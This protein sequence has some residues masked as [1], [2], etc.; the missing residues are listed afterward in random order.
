MAFLVPDPGG[1]DDFVDLGVFG[2]P[3]EFG[4]GFFAAGDEEGGVA[5]A[6]REHFHG[7]GVASDAADGID[8]FANSEAGA[9][10][11]VV[12]EALF[13]G[14]VGFE[15]LEGEQM[16]V[17]QVGDVDV[18]ADAGAVVGGVVVAEDFDGVATAEGH[19]EDERDQVGFGLVGLTLLDDAA[20][21]AAGFG[22]SGY[23]EV[24]QRGRAQ[25]VDP[26]EPVKDVFDEELGFAVGVGGLEGGCLG[27]RNCLGLA[28]NGGGGAEDEAFGAAGEDGFEQG[29][30]GSS[31]VPEIDFRFLHGFAGFDE[32]GE[33]ENAVKGG[34]G[35]G[36]GAEK[37]FD[38]G[39]VGDVGF[40]EFDSRGY[41]GALGMAEIVDDD[42]FM[43]L[44]VE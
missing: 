10:A 25:A 26:V 34:S 36:G 20:S 5:G 13:G 14:F 11:E 2:L 1:V 21:L 12:D 39:A 22:C 43:P 32:G 42:H 9:V 37:A 19:V 18:I 7:D 17:C 4:D 23:V 40:D 33:V 44:L 3:A 24:A 35:G 31:V 30:G 41:T 8:N 29:Q 38:P 27:D 6:A 16:G 28:V 15:G